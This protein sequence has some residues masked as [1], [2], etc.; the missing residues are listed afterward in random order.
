MWAIHD[1]GAN[2]LRM[3]TG[4]PVADTAGVVS[5]H[6]LALDMATEDGHDVIGFTLT[7]ASHYLPLGAGAGYDVRHDILT[8]GDT[9]DDPDLVTQNGDFIGYWAVSRANPNGFRDPIGVA[10]RRA[11]THLGDENLKVY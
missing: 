1:R 2:V 6:D 5:L 10:V 8:I 11:S 9:T 4:E 3:G 7:G